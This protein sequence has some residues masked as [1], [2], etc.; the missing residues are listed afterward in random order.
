MSTSCDRLQDQYS[1]YFEDA[2]SPSEV[3]EFERHLATCDACRSDYHV[4][5]TMFQFLDRIEVTE[6]DSPTSLR[7]EILT[8]ISQRPSAKRFSFK[9]WFGGITSH[10]QMGW[11]LGTAVAALVVV[12]VVLIA[13]PVQK[14]PAI[15]PTAPAAMGPAVSSLESSIP[16][17]V[18][19]VVLKAGTDG[20]DYEYFTLHS[21][22]FLT[23]TANVKAFVLQDGDPLANAA[24]ESD[25]D[26]A[27]PAW[28]GTLEPNVSVNL[29]VSVTSDVQPGATLNLLLDW[30]TTD[31]S[32]VGGREVA[33][34]PITPAPGATSGVPNGSLFYDAVSAI[35]GQYHETIVA[36]TTA[37]NALTSSETFSGT[38]GNE[39]NAEDALNS[40][41]VSNGFTVT[42]EAGGYYLIS[43]P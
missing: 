43:H 24:L 13:H 18:Q 5:A 40:V 35:A 22:Q 34:V 41:L 10:P 4:F 21:P 39:L 20:N 37:L 12:L 3:A 17:L 31:G 30:S 8:H 6:V 27:T 7:A 2:L 32:D 29:P 38:T 15:T 23:G 11:G 33:F 16:P 26:Q 42:P 14:S 28:S 36:D 9:E 19:T 1:D 25:A